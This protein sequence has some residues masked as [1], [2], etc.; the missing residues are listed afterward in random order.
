MT[1]LPVLSRELRVAARRP[2]T[3]WARFLFALAALIVFE[4]LWLTQSYITAATQQGQV[5]FYS[6]A[7]LA[8]WFALLS[9]IANAADSI[10]QEEKPESALPFLLTD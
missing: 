7:S 4:W 6:L 5:L 8:Y 3:Y 10:S 2:N 9:G 1:M